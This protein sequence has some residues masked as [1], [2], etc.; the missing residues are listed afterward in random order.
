[1]EC[2]CIF[3]IVYGYMCVFVWFLLNGYANYAD[4]A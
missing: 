3:V 2:M 1:M 4:G